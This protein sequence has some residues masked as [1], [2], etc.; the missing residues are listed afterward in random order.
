MRRRKWRCRACDKTAYCGE[1]RA[2]AAIESI[3][4]INPDGHIPIRAYPCPYSNGWHITSQN[5][6]RTA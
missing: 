4:Q 3:Q 6:R 1:R 2:L 5:E